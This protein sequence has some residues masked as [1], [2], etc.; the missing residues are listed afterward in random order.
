LISVGSVVQIYSGPP[1]FAR[2]ASVGWY[3]AKVVSP[4]LPRAA[5]ADLS[6]EMRIAESLARG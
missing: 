6:R 2:D 5:K 3:T 1:T 4:K